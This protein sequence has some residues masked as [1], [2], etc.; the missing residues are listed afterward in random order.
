MAGPPPDIP[1]WWFATAMSLAVLILG[2]AKSGFGGGIGI[3]AVPLMAHALRVDHA[4]GVMLP[5][6]LAADTA[7]AWQHRGSWS[8]RHIRDTVSSAIVGIGIGT[9]LLYQM[10][11]SGHLVP[12]L[13][14]VVGAV[15]LT[16]VA[17]Q[18]WRLLGGRFPRIPDTTPSAIAAG[19][20]CGVV[21]TVSHSA[22]P[23]MSIYLLEHRLEKKILVG[24]LVLFFYAVNAAK[25]PTYVALGLIGT[26]TLL[27]S[28][29]FLPLVPVGAWLGIWMHRRV[30]ERPFVIV[31]YLGATAAGIRMLAKAL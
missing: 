10:Q 11:S 7:A 22:G 28:A 8:R 20:L 31:M 30:P 24:T 18:V 16:F 27:T 4:V 19:T 12:I 17:I 2:V 3:I 5:L 26:D 29:L 15:C 6:L 14:G 21:S 23:I 25:V 1:M 9:A 13:N